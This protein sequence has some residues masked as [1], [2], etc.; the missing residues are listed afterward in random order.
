MNS[1]RRAT[2]LA[3]ILIKA[4]PLRSAAGALRAAL[5]LEAPLARA[6]QLDAPSRLT[7]VAH[8]RFGLSGV[9]RNPS[10]GLRVAYGDGL[11]PLPTEPGRESPVGRQ[12]SGMG[13]FRYGIM[14]AWLS[15]RAGR[16]QSTDTSKTRATP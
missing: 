1:A 13:T 15:T 4:A 9:D 11:R 3:L 16:T 8:P 12:L 10:R 6:R 2:E 7:K 14:A 5:W